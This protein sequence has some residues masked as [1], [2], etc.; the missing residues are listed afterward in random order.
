M[1]FSTNLS[2]MQTIR[3]HWCVCVWPKINSYDLHIV[4]IKFNSL[5]F[6]VNF[7]IYGLS[8]HCNA[9]MFF[10]LSFNN[11][12][13]LCA[14]HLVMLSNVHVQ[15]MLK[16]ILCKSL[17]SSQIFLFFFFNSIESRKKILLLTDLYWI[18]ADVIR[19]QHVLNANAMHF[20]WSEVET[21]TFFVIPK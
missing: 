12:F 10:F 21:Q 6:H 5:M 14:A 19:F 9:Y 16:W 11:L 15:S 2:Q 1:K 17:F 8:M 20:L 18:Y 7:K 13:A 4:W 3:W